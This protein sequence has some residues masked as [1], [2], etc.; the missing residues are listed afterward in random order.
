MG[1]R[2][3]TC[4]C[5]LL[6]AVQNNFIYSFNVASVGFLASWLL[7]FV[8][9]CLYGDAATWISCYP[10]RRVYSCMV[11]WTLILQKKTVRQGWISGKVP[12]SILALLTFQIKGQRMGDIKP[13]NWQGK[14]RYVYTVYTIQFSLDLPNKKIILAW[15]FSV[16]SDSKWGSI[17]TLLSG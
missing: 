17:S 14:S 5:L 8:A 13:K 16:L 3:G 15:P 11:T 6:S 10:S 12:L 1:S 2:W 9:A 4:N 7:G